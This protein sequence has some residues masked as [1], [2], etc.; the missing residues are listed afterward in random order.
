MKI[1]DS[2]YIF[3][4]KFA[5][6]KKLTC[7]AFCAVKIHEIFVI[8][9]FFSR[10]QMK[11]CWLYWE[12]IFHHLKILSYLYTLVW[13]IHLSLVTIILKLKCTTFLSLNN[14]YS[15]CLNSEQSNVEPI[16]LPN[17]VPLPFLM[18]QKQNGNQNGLALTIF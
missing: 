9:L 5:M 14:W 10:G 16:R 1:W 2:V 18:D 17:L 15:K 7:I 4:R 13:L 12:L 8:C 11:C 3:T 6:L